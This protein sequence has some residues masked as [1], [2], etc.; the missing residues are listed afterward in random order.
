MC[1]VR[2]TRGVD[3]K[4]PVYSTSRYI[5]FF[6]LLLNVYIGTGALSAA[7]PIIAG[8]RSLTT[9]LRTKAKNKWNS[10]CA[11]LYGSMTCR[12]ITFPSFHMIL[13]W[14]PEATLSF[15]SDIKKNLKE[16]G[17][18]LVEWINVVCEHDHEPSAFIKH[19]LFLVQPSDY[20]F[21]KKKLVKLS[22]GVIKT[23]HSLTNSGSSH[24]CS[25]CIFRNVRSS[26]LLAGSCQKERKCDNRSG[27]YLIATKRDKLLSVQ[28]SYL[29]R[30]FRSLRSI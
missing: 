28:R 3:E 27:R 14:Y 18:T 17:S 15:K 30:F 1:G 9:R 23:V 12:M 21:L 16:I 6:S 11:P 8:A 29:S 25:W 22:L 19:A 10:V 26:L 20:Q 24:L 13:L 7:Y 5:Y 2:S 4:Y